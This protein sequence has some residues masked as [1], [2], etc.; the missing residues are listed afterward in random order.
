VLPEPLE[1]CLPEEPGFVGERPV[2]RAVLDLPEYL[3]QSNPSC[4]L[5]TIYL[6][7]NPFAY[8]S[9]VFLEYNMQ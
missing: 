3:S 2:D 8:I 5:K 4:R 6:A 9:F 7:L 1:V